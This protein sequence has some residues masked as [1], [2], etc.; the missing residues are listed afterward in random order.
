MLL[1]GADEEVADWVSRQLFDVNGY[2]GLCR[3]I[4]ITLENKLICGVVYNNQHTRPDGTPYMLEMSV[5]SIDKRWCSRHNLRALFEFPFSQLCLERVQTHCNST[6]EGTIMFNQRLG[7][8]EEGLHPSHW[9]LGGDSISFGMLRKECP[10]V[11][12]G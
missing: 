4:G 9:S 12:H 3:A 11:S 7:F 6:D 5:A 2:F 8:I 1:Y 10:W